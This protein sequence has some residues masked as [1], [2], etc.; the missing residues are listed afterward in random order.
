ML[1]PNLGQAVYP[2]WWPSLTKD[3][4]T[5]QLLCCSGITDTEHTTS[6][7]NEDGC[8]KNVYLQYFLFL[9]RVDGL[10]CNYECPLGLEL[11]PCKG[12][13]CPKTCMDLSSVVQ[14]VNEPSGKLRALL[15]W[16]KV[17]FIWQLLHAVLLT[18][19][20]VL[21]VLNL[22]ECCDNIFALFRV[23]T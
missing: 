23:T 19:N 16:L 12:T 5:E 15:L 14:C 7:S 8:V 17:H 22:S 10:K 11:D 1:F 9:F 2:L 4:H 13:N 20:A 3:M 18:A 6:D 21:R